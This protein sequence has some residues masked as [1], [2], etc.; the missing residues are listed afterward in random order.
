[1][2]LYVTDQYGGFHGITS[3]EISVGDWTHVA[4]TWDGTTLS[5][6]LNGSLDSWG[7]PELSATG[8]SG[9]PFCIGGVN[10][11]CGY[12]GQYFNGLL[13]EVSLYDR[14]LVD[15]EISAIYNAGS[16]GKCHTAQPCAVLPNS[17]VAQWRGDGDASDLFQSND[18][19]LQN[20][21]GFMSGVVSQ[22]FSFNS[23][24]DQAMEIPYS[25]ALA[26]S[27]FSLEAWV[28]PASQ[29]PSPDDHAFVFG[30]SFGRQ[31]AVRGGVVGLEVLF[32][33]STDRLNFYDMYGSGEIPIGE[34]THLVG[35]W[36][37]TN[38]SLYING[39]LDQQS[40]PGM[41]PWD[42]GCPWH[43]GG[44]NDPSG[45]CSYTGQYLDGLV[46]EATFYSDALSPDQVRAAYNAKAAGKCVPDPY[47]FLQ[48][49]GQTA[50]SGG[51]A[52]FT[53]SVHG[54][55][56][57]S[58]QWFHDGGAM[59]GGT[60]ASLNLIGISHFDAAE[61]NVVVWNSHGSATSRQAALA[62]QQVMAPTF[63]PVG[64]SY[65]SSRNVAI[66]CAS[67]GATIHYTVN[68]QDPTLSDP[69][70][71]SG[72]TVLV[73]HNLTLKAKA[74]KSGWTTSATESETYRIE[75]N[76]TDIPP[77]VTIAPVDGTITL[78]SDDLPILVQV[79]RTR[80]GLT[81]RAF[82]CSGTAWQLPPQ[83]RSPL[84]VPP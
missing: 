7:Q 40:P 64:G 50:S 11:A 77:V 29:L 67:S 72:S 22:A 2:S 12:F 17:T 15:C 16:D 59:P 42:S 18:G 60:S 21:A 80:T 33:V 31:L 65:T 71:A 28:K 35:T 74:F 81:L 73:D 30:Q 78:A 4:G 41:V 44:V 58:Y 46:D 47:I 57:L 20:G 68:G 66:S 48:P 76:P 36:D 13:D 61:Y 32:A 25:A 52:A 14:A 23:A 45:D 56:P 69:T 3:D 49:S 63:S 70:I 34:W 75:S 82:S 24:S 79:S 37:G 51:N 55:A 8:D 26:T 39:T 84:Q 54:T 62:N 5:L 83:L 10:D 6:Y 43:I 1:M 53:V 38:L 27:A 9:C 19:A